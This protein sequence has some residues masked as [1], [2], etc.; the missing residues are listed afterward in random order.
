MIAENLFEQADED[1]S[2]SGI[3]EELLDIRKDDSV[4]VPKECGTHFNTAGVKRNVVTTKGRE[5]QVK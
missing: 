3:F 2:D 4:A 5:V 1:G